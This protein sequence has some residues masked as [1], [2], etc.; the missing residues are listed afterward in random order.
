MVW[1]KHQASFFFSS[2]GY[3][4]VPASFI[5]KITL[6]P[7]NHLGYSSLA[8]CLDSAAIL[9]CR[10]FPI[11]MYLNKSIKP[12]A[13]GLV[14]LPFPFLF[15][16]VG[17]ESLRPF[18]YFYPCSAFRPGTGSGKWPVGKSKTLACLGAS[19]LSSAATFNTLSENSGF[20]T[21]CSRNIIFLITGF[22]RAMLVW[23][24]L[25][26]SYLIRN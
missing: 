17:Q 6:F 5:E 23:A 4:V 18:S 8:S 24:V 10:A 12:W 16:G 11:K 13:S 9:P 3:P 26:L 25:I 21:F 19:H 7:L 22:H 14:I 1:G 15:S 20:Q 2:C